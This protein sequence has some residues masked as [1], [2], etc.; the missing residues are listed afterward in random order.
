M[1][2]SI[3]AW[4]LILVL[5]LQSMIPSYILGIVYMEH[6]LNLVKQYPGLDSS[7]SQPLISLQTEDIQKPE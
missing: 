1:H 4:S 5:M 2:I 7:I 3:P 6:E